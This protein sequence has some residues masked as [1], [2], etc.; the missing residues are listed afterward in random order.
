MQEDTEE[1]NIVV[2]DLIPE[3]QD[4]GQDLIPDKKKFYN[5]FFWDFPLNFFIFILFFGK[6]F[7]E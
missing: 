4:Q 2:Q 6:F 1:R 5:A 7:F 3:A